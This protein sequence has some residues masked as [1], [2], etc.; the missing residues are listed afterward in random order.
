MLG[1]SHA[2]P[3]LISQEDQCTAAR[4]AGAAQNGAEGVSN[5]VNLATQMYG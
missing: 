3:F 4:S 1:K 5:T 2:M